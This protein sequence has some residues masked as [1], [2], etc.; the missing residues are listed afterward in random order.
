MIYVEVSWQKNKNI[1]INIGYMFAGLTD[2]DMSI[3]TLIL[4]DHS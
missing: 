3:S 2:D 4:L 1:Y